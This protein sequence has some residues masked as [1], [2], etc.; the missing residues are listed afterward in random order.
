MNNKL[1]RLIA[2]FLAVIPLTLTGCTSLSVLSFTNGF[3]AYLGDVDVTPGYTQTLDYSVYYSDTEYFPKDQTIDDNVKIEF[4]NGNYTSTLTALQIL[5]SNIE[6]LAFEDTSS[7]IS[8]T[9]SGD[10]VLK[11]TTRFNIT[12]VYTEGDTEYK[13]DDFIYT[14]VYFAT[15]KYSFAPIFSK[16]YSSYTI[17]NYANGIYL[18]YVSDVQSE[19]LYLS[20][21]YTVKTRTN[22][23][24]F[25]NPTE[26]NINT[27]EWNTQTVEYTFRT[28]IDNTQL[29]FALRNITVESENVFMLPTVSPVYKEH[30]ALRIESSA[31]TE[32]TFDVEYNG[33]AY[34]EEKIKVTNLN[35]CINDSTAQGETKFVSIQKEGSNNIPNMHL[36]VS[37]AEPLIYYQSFLKMG[38][39]VFK[40]KS[41]N[42]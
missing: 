12:S 31:D 42:V 3:S 7:D 33:N 1:R 22:A 17:A 41:I 21:S 39:L 29:L 34:T 14:E 27:K 5:P 11:L 18:F 8:T 28:L 16:S 40:I 30:K 38:A 35:F 26:S 15:K 2:L 9:I 13:H 6:S 20:D 23:Y 24:T 10:G 36:P 37:F 25:D 19:T 4:I 32:N